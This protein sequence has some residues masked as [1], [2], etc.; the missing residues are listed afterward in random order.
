MQKCKS[1]H[2]IVQE[3][4]PSA[5]IVQSTAPEPME[6]L[7]ACELQCYVEKLTGVLLPIIEW[8][9]SASQYQTLLCVGHPDRLQPAGEAIGRA[10]DLGALKPDSYVI[11]TGVMEGSAVM[12][13]S[14]REPIGTLYAVYHLLEMLGVTFLLT[15]DLLPE[16]VSSLSAPDLSRAFEPAFS[17]RGFLIPLINLH[18][19][20]LSLSDY[21]QL[22][23]Q[24]VKLRLNYLSFFS[25]V[26]E[27][28]AEY[29]F[30]GEK[31]LLGDVNSMESGYL[32]P[33][34]NLPDVSTRQ[35]R[36]GAR[37]FEGREK[38]APPEMEDV[39]SQEE[40][41]RRS[42]R[43]MQA[44]FRCAKSKGMT[45]G[46][47]L[48]P[49]HLS[50]NLARF[51]RKHGHR[52]FNAVYG[53][54]GKPADPV[55]TEIAEQRLRALFET[56]PDVD[57]VFLWC[58]E[59]YN[60][61]RDPDSLRLYERMRPDFAEARRTVAENWGS[62]CEKF[63]RTPDEIVDCDMG[64]LDMV[65]K[66]V[67]VAR[68]LRPD[69]RTGICFLFRGYLLQG[70]DRVVDREI[71]FMDFQSSGVFPI[72][73]DVNA[74]Y[75]AN[76][77]ARERHIIPRVDDDGSM[78]GMPFYLRQYQ[79]DGLFGEALSAGVSGF[80]GQ[81]FRARGT[82]H[83]TR[84]LAQGAWE[85]DLTPDAFYDRYAR[86]IFGP[87]AAESMKAA[88]DLL[89]ECEEWLGW[90]GG[91]NFSWA[92]GI[93]DLTG[94][95]DVL[96]KQENPFDGPPDGEGMVT[97]ARDREA[98]FA[99]AVGLLEQALQMMAGALPLVGSKGESM[100]NY[101]ISKTHTYRA[102]MEMLVLLDRAFGCYAQAFLDHADEEPA[103]T[104]DLDAAEEIFVA[105]G[106]KAR[107]TAKRAAEIVDHP[108]DLAILFLVNVWSVSRVDEVIA[109]VRRVVNYHH[110]GPYWKEDKQSKGSLKGVAL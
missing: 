28:W 109:L 76:M 60:L 48:D 8:P 70:A 81:L 77:G 65:I 107:E 44:V 52:P 62:L 101:L 1:R 26:P 100:L 7:A 46:L 106:I 39:R 17:R 20:M 5:A 90:R 40:A 27:P 95:G 85:P 96:L 83:H 35:V 93:S 43:L 45:V 78:L 53:T 88:F 110:G 38:M 10:F 69:V 74:R 61:S 11:H 13:L 9:G 19:S 59:D 15:G 30:R 87:E 14:G 82:E 2:F 58:S 54:P 34:L 6:T 47:S 29:T 36:I 105:A 4:R 12:A 22:I 56:Y 55:V 99:T 66:V 21:Q 33:K 103:L 32:R 75:F 31:N 71:P 63:N 91:N 80:V 51:A 98:L 68:R 3:G 94:L 24:M 92:G 79:K 86:E 108:N 97:R 104:M 41:Y 18:S 64:L 67:E 25:S 23:E 16:P 102:H 89:E 72:K 37:H 57:D 42:S 73:K 50:P 49:C 84:F